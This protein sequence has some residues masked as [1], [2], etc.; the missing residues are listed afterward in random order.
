M[1]TEI[2]AKWAF[3][4]E[5]VCLALSSKLCIKQ[6]LKVCNYKYTSF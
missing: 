6:H 1:H 3:I 2:A 5:E 4:M